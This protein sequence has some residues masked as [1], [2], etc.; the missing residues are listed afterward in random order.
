[1]HRVKHFFFR[2]LADRFGPDRRL[3]CACGR[4]HTLT[5]RT[6]LVD[7]GALEESARR[8]RDAL[9]DRGPAWIISDE[10]TEAAAGARWKAA[11]APAP[12]VERILKAQPLPVPT[13]ALV[14]AL[15]VE[16]RAAR[17]ALVVSVGS[18]VVSDLGKSVSLA[19][20][21]PNWCIATAPSVDAYA[22]AT[23]AL[24]V[25]GFHNAVEARVSDLIACEPGVQAKAPRELFLAGLGDLL[26]KFFAYLDW[27]LAGWVTGEYYCPFIATA[28][29]EA[30]RGALKA[31][32]LAA[33]DPAE[34][35]RLLTDAALCSG[36]A[37]QA[38]GGSRPAASAEHLLAHFWETKDAARTARYNLHG[39]LAAAASR[40]LLPAYRALYERLPAFEPDDAARLAAF[41]REPRWEDSL[42]EGLAPFRQ[43]VAA[44]AAARTFNRAILARRLDAFRAQRTRIAA[45]AATILDEMEGSVKEL[46]LQG[47]PFSP[48]VLGLSREDIMLPVRNARLL[49]ARWSSFDLAYE[50]GLP[51]L[52]PSVV[53]RLVG[54]SW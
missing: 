25:N 6:I 1:V 10:N 36:L 14:E 11:A 38:A 53:E 49:R 27:N 8:L 30:A 41:D 51:G 47:Y 5:T 46:E 37:M 35:A 16:A 29:L 44:E 20:G 26:A 15:A 54:G 42:E 43:K 19:L 12:V 32:A 39:I 23:S 52:M 45:L 50:V 7:E 9:A 4:V 22:S 28:S 40:Y 17:P 34:A 13:G 2:D 48:A 24:R 18:G 33:D 3:A 31:G 21:V